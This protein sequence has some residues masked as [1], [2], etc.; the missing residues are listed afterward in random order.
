MKRKT[1]CAGILLITAFLL[2]TILIMTVDRQPVGQ[3][4]TNIGLATLN[5]RF[6]KLTGV[7]MTLYTVTD[8]LGLVPIFICTVFGFNGL[9]QLFKRKSLFKVDRDLIVLGVYYIV[10]ISAYLIFEMIPINYRPVLINGF[11]EASYPSSTTLLVI[12]VM[13]TLAERINRRCSNPLLKKATVIFSAVFSVFMIAGRLLSGVHWLTD[14]VAS[15]LLGIGLFCIYKYTV[16]T[17]G[18]IKSK[19]EF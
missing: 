17:C 2:F 7:N 1:L 9:V 16:L 4:G 12:C 14:I 8:W 18:K 19:E 6:H 11:L 5:C 13:P 15:L 3:N 10:V